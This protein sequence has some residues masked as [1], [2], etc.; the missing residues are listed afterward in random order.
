MRRLMFIIILMFFFVQGVSVRAVTLEDQ[1]MPPELNAAYQYLKSKRHLDALKKLSEYKY[2]PAF[3]WHYHFIYAR[4][5]DGINNPLDAIDHMRLAYLYAP[6]GD[7]KEQLLLERANLYFKIKYYYEAK[8]MYQIFLKKFPDSKNTSDANLGIA[9]SLSQIGLVKEALEYYKKSGDVSEASF[10]I[11]NSLQRLGSIN[12]ANNMYLYAVSKDSS[13]MK[14]SDETNYYYGEN[15]RQLGKLSEAKM[16]LST[17]KDPLFKYKADIELGM[18]AVAEERIDQGIKRFKSALFSTDRSVKRL[19]LLNLAKIEEGA[20]RT[21][22]AKALLEEIRYKYP[23]G[24]DYDD[25]I[26]QLSRIYVKDGD[27]NKAVSILKEL[28]FRHYP[29]IKAVDQFEKI[30]ANIDSEQFLNIWKSVGSW[31]IDASREQFLLNSAHKLKNSATS[32]IKVYQYLARH[33]SDAAKLRSY[34]LLAMFYV[35]LGDIGKGNEYLGKIKGMKGSGDDVLRIEAMLAYAQRDSASAY[36]KIASIKNFNAN[37]IKILKNTLLSARDFKK[38]VTI[39]ESALKKVDQEAQDAEANIFLADSHY[40]AGNKK[41]AINYYK[42]SLEI[43]PNNE[44]ALY[45]I[46]ILLDSQSEDQ[47]AASMLKRI[48]RSGSVISGL[49]EAILREKDISKSLGGIF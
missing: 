4:A 44:W 33:G 41:E 30:L 3:L 16:Y 28:V 5:S 19:A 34:I 29:H 37:D 42:K 32:F 31:L 21:N 26:I 46:G 25:A 23:Y 38:A 6:E 11:A 18:I 15:L 1:S 47:E 12:E 45:R 13:Y 35:E 22:E 40:K 48:S 36:E 24:K 27:L 39:Y 7:V 17:V 10:G 49:A 9:R 20:E 2:D 8:A 14:T 43:D